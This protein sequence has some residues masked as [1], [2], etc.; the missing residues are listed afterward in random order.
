MS[1]LLDSVAELLGREPPKKPRPEDV[2]PQIMDI[3][4]D[5]HAD[6][7]RIE[8]IKIELAQKAEH[9]APEKLRRKRWAV[10]IAVNLLFV[11]SYQLDIQMLE[12]ALT[13]SRFS[14]AQSR[15]VCCRLAISVMI[16]ACF[17]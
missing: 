5:K 10:L 15:S 8:K 7:S 2:A 4:R 16:P 11:L 6:K 14:S 13:A 17:K 1:R 12:G 9:A 3:H